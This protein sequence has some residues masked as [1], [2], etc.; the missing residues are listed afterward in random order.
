MARKFD[1][2]RPCVMHEDTFYEYFKPFRHAEAQYNIWGGHGLETFGRDFE[3]V[4]RHDPAFVWTVVDGDSGSDQWITTG[5][6]YVNRVCYLVTEIARDSIPVE[7][8]VRSGPHSLT[9]LGLKRQML[10][11]ERMLARP[12]K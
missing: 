1:M 5:V 6:H 3:I 4:C 9:P 8:R 7:F 12:G 2:R 10:K 11:L